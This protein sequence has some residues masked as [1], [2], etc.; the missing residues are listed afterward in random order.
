MVNVES[1][2][3]S[4][5]WS[6]LQAR[7]QEARVVAAFR[8][9]R[10][11]GIEPILIK[12]WAAAR[13]YPE[14]RLRRT[15]DVDLAV[16]PEDFE[17]AREIVRFPDVAR[18]NIDLHNGLRD[19]D[20]R[21]WPDL[22]ARSQ[23]AWIGDEPIRLLSD[24]DHLRILC[25]HWLVDGGRYRDK[26][27]DIYYAVENCGTS[28]DWERCLDVPP[29][30]RRWVICAVTLAQ[31]Y[32]GLRIDDL[33]FASEIGAVPNWVIRSVE[34]EWRRPYDLEPVLVTTDDPK[35]FLHQITR[36]LP[37]N[38]IRATIE[39]DGEIFGNRRLL[40]QL[41]VLARRALPFLTNAIDL[42]R[43]RSAK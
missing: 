26:L 32:L 35:L 40:Y 25:V 6:S 38:P 4:D 12:G 36:R 1:M 16:A 28:F 34:Q 8:E 9:F 2:T 33:P 7:V 29:N 14:G 18:H 20:T 10:N 27:W 19:L 15:G 22:F 21:P 5:R 31:K 17:K 41:R 13:K 42:V 43:K 3:E 30:R 37:P 39:A 24:E 23:I 11:H